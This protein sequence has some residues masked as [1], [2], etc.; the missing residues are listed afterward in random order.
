MPPL[1]PLTERG[2]RL[3][4]LSCGENS[5]W[6]PPHEI[7]QGE[8]LRILT[9]VS[10]SSS[11]AVKLAVELAR[12]TRGSLVFMYVLR[13]N[14]VRGR[15][16]CVDALVPAE[17][18]VQ[19]HAPFPDLFKKLTVAAFEKLEECL[20]LAREEG[21]EA[22]VVVCEGEYASTIIGEAERGYDLVVLSYVKLDKPLREI[23]KEITAPTL[24]VKEA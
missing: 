24:L 16:V 8:K 2:R 7:V 4:H 20:A 3:P 11:R 19:V 22:K 10:E 1:R 14:V 5:F 23:L 9:V 13:R 21:V 12:L 6:S 15:R 18:G 17:E